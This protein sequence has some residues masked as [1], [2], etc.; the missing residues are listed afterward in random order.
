MPDVPLSDR[1]NVTDAMVRAGLCAIAER[2]AERDG[3][4]SEGIRERHL[5]EMRE[6]ELDLDLRVAIAAALDDKQGA[7]E[8]GS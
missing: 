1:S 8:G 4:S 3:L 6:N 7:S 2:W 5:A